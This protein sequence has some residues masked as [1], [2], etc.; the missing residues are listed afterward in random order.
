MDHRNRPLMVQSYVPHFLSTSFVIL[1]VH[2][3]HEGWLRSEEGYDNCIGTNYNYYVTEAGSSLCW[4]EESMCFWAGETGRQ[5]EGVIGLHSTACTGEW[6]H[7]SD[8]LALCATLKEN[9]HWFCNR[10]KSI[11]TFQC[12]FCTSFSVF[13]RHYSWQLDEAV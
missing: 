6:L 5:Q 8:Y 3:R 1:E 9:Y 10:I 7:F 12:L 2:I 13:S 11:P 4:L